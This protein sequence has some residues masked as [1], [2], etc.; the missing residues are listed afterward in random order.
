MMPVG[1]PTLSLATVRDPV[2]AVG[3]MAVES[4]SILLKEKM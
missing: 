1:L 2:F 3:H 4:G